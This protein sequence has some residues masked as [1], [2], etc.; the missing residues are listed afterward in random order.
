MSARSAE[1]V[2]IVRA[3]RQGS[4]YL[5]NS[6]LILTSAHL[7]DGNDN[8]HVA[9]PG[10]TGVQ[11][12][13]LIW[14]RYDEACD[15]A[16]LEANEDLVADA[17]KCQISHIKWGRISGLSAWDGCEA[18]GYP[19][20]S[21]WEGTRPDTEQIVG[22][23]K[24]GSS[25]LRGRYVLDSAH[26][27]PPM[28]DDSSQSPWQ[29][30][31]GA[32]LFVGDYLIGVV[33]GDPVQ[34]GHA[35][36]EAVPVSALLSDPD[37]KRAV[38]EVGGVQ[39]ELTEVVKQISQVLADSSEF[40][41]QPVSEADPIGFG[42][43]RVPDSPG[44]SQ[45]VEY[46]SRAVDGQLDEQLESLADAGGMLL[47]T[48][49][50]AAGKSRALFEGMRRKLGEWLVCKPDPDAE[51]SSLISFVSGERRVVWLD[52]LH[53]Y[54]R[55]DGLTSS[56]LDGLISR[57]V[58]VL[59]TLRTDFYEHYTDEKDISSISRGVGPRLP[60][61][62]GRILRRA[63]HIA[64][65]RIW[66]DGE[67]KIAS[68]S[69]DPRIS[70]ALKSDRAY[71]LA[72]YLAAGPQVLKLWRSASRAKGNP[73]GA[74]LVSAAIALA[75]TGV[76]SSLPPDA[77]ERLHNHYLDQA[78]GP[79]LR[80]EG[81]EE[82]W[83]WAARIVL[84]VTSPL[85]PSKGGTWKPFDYLVSD[86]A[87]H[88][89]PSDLPDQVWEE[90]LRVVD[91]SRRVAVATVARVAGRLDT[92]KDALRP[93][94][95]IDDPDGL[96]NLGA[97]LASENDYEGASIY[98]HRASDL[99]D[100]TGTHNM[101]SLC[102]A[103]G[104]LQGARDWYTL[105]IE[106]GEL[107][108]I[109]ALGLVS[110]KLGNKD[111][112]VDLWKRGTEVGDPGSALHYSDWLTSK[113]QSDDAVEALRV[114]ADGAIP[115]AAL[116][117]AGV[118]LR[119]KDHKTAN[120]Y[121][122]KAYD[123]AVQQGHLGDPIGYLMAGVTAYSFG[124]VQ[125]GEEW[126]SRARD[127]G[128]Q[129]DWCVLEAPDDFP[130]LRYLATSLDTLDKLGH[131]G[132]RLLMQILWAGDCL[133]CGHPLKEGVP[134]LYVDDHYTRADA[135]LFHFGLC[136]FPRWNESA[137]TTFAKDA[138][139]SWKSFSAG[140][141]VGGQV[142]PALIVN[143]S[144]EV[145]QLL[146][147]DQVWTATG[148]YGPQST[149]GSALHLQPL[150]AG[151]PPKRSDS[152]AWAFVGD[153]EVAVAVLHQIWSAPASGEL[154]ALV[155]RYGGLLLIVTSALGPEGSATIEGLTNVLESWDSMT[156]WVPLRESHG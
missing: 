82:A 140:V 44:Y 7:F 86:V 36:V 67:R 83:N 108:S 101:G 130:G 43:H 15:A 155:K 112:A 115:L 126:W 29:G 110:E 75:R 92:A 104:D 42:V 121:V 68:L 74:A 38:R 14:R 144:L 8:A 95:E 134:A 96:I 123:A 16:L 17:S 132:T 141:P 33:C 19:R 131:E 51:L 50:S 53:D 27:A 13:R 24:P 90:A 37:F 102:F 23:L 136:R 28:T 64:L 111:E 41:W 149:L 26:S 137:L 25:V 30:M 118:L 60:S 47:L 107:Q 154:V 71:G 5:L 40:H 69:E 59:A 150:W 70:E 117:Y 35:R 49:D 89:H 32:A 6:R 62:P 116:S 151:L 97:L 100:S 106:R 3:A 54:L 128:C 142:V 9:V 98:F 139:I 57:R 114:A 31:S 143:P 80:P 55:S 22:T 66:S 125:M 65:E 153:D 76:D 145:A 124:N 12:C 119:K 61:S 138:G 81:L 48:G 87:R 77:V 21:F 99:G 46:V 58:A 2:A 73:R 152:L 56:L 147:D 72:E 20:I 146:L 84:G 39:P 18:I 109:G 11:R 113:W 133:D 88:S 127:K 79:A 4:G 1:R 103:R 34:W 148:M 63:H 93:L 85:V 91:N 52:D 78:G 120:T 122:S 105:A 135:R 94:V 156:R 10:G 45:I 129:I